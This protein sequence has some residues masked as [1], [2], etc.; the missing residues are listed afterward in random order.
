MR[1]GLTPL[2]F[3]TAP[4]GRNVKYAGKRT[5]FFDVKESEKGDKYLVISESSQV[6]EE[7]KHHRVMVFEEHVK[8]FNYALQETIKFIEK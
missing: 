8:E 5:Y 3:R 2:P 4:F 6:G 7:Y 1:F